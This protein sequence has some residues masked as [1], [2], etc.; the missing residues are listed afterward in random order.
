MPRNQQTPIKIP[1][2]RERCFAQKRHIF[3]VRNI[4]R[5]KRKQEQAAAKQ[6]EEGDIFLRER[7]QYTKTDA[8]L[9][10][11]TALNTARS[12]KTRLF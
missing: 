11:F 12:V 4:T 1:S 10:Q 9:T 7:R 6:V 3:L 8:F 2:Y 5:A